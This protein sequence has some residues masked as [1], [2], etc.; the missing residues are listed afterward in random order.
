MKLG[1]LLDAVHLRDLGEH[2]LQQPGRIEQ[3]KG[4]AS[5]ALGEHAGEFV[6]HT[7]PT[8]LMN[9]AGMGADRSSSALLDRE[10]KACG[11]ADGAEHAELV[12]LKSQTRTADGPNESR[13]EIGA[14]AHKIEHR[15]V[16][17]AALCL[18]SEDRATCR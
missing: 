18:A 8:H 9:F 15:A 13:I 12:L 16:D 17:V 3:L 7:F 6:A 5:L 11:E 2:L 1:R 14:S 4:T 10:P